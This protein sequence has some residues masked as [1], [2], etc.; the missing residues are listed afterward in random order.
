MA[1]HDFKIFPLNLEKK[2]D[3]CK[4]IQTFKFYT[5]INNINNFNLSIKNSDL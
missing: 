1:K 4:D 3:I 2:I 5:L